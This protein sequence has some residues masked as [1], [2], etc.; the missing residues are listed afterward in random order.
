MTGSPS[1]RATEARDVA[2]LAC[3][4]LRSVIVVLT[5][6]ANDSK[7]R[8]WVGRSPSDVRAPRFPALRDWQGKALS[9]WR[10]SGSR[11]IV[12]VA[13]GGGKTIFA[14]TAA[15]E[16]LRANTDG[17][18]VVIVPTAALQDQ[19]VV[20][21]ADSFGLDGHEVA[22]WPGSGARSARF[23]VMIVNTARKLAR[24]VASGRAVLLIADECHRYASPENAKAIAIDACASLG[25]TATAEREYDDGLDDVLVPILGPVIY[26][27]DLAQARR[28]GVVSPFDLVNVE[29]PLTDSERRDYERL[30]KRLRLL[31]NREDVDEAMVKQ[32]ALRRSALVKAARLR[33]PTTVALM[34][35]QRGRRALV[36]HEDVA[37]ANALTSM[38]ASRGHSVG[39]YHSR[40]GDALRRDNLRQ[41]RDGLLD[42][43][44][45]CRALDEGVDVP[46]AEMAV[47]AAASASRRQRIQRL[48][49]VLRTTDTKLRASVYTLYATESEE[50]RLVDEQRLLSDSAGVTWLRA[51]VGARA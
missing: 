37:S 51:S 44:V 32:A 39:V 3:F 15:A 31:M 47:I 34:N 35:G 18:V 46:E 4:V 26:V 50:S 11:G 9:V 2:V 41:F 20:A 36:F 10:A 29:V 19:W 38:L 8:R 22:T 45:A 13:T 40:L 24:V 12:E 6:T 25:L 43:L 27:Y 5:E 7:G 23:H 42:V 17:L 30:T 28:D 14:L 48:G 21:I 33:L 16:W 1:R 49:R